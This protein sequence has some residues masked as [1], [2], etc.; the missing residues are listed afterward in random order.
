[1]RKCIFRKAQN[2]VLGRAG[3]RINP[4]ILGQHLSSH[5][6]LCSLLAY[7]KMMCSMLLVHSSDSYRHMKETDNPMQSYRG[8]PLGKEAWPQAAETLLSG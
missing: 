1:M 8:K 3:P 6:P 5:N 7:D 2:L 4:S